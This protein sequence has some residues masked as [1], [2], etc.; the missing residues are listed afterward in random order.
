MTG[1]WRKEAP[2]NRDLCS[3]AYIVKLKHKV[4]HYG[5]QLKQKPA[6]IL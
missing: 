2:K 6:G 5:E 4:L 3:R 1:K